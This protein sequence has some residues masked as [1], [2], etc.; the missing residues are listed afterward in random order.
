M[1]GW[2]LAVETRILMAAALGTGARHPR[3][4]VAMRQVVLLACVTEPAVQAR[5]LATPVEQKL[6]LLDPVS[7]DLPLRSSAPDVTGPRSA[8]YGSQRHGMNIPSLC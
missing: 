8:P 7:V 5:P 4:A 1:R 6:L 2:P 3:R